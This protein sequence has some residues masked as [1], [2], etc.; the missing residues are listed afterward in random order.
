MKKLTGSILLV[1][2]PNELADLRYCSGFTAVD[3]V[4]F[5]WTP[6]QRWLVVP[7]MEVGRAKREVKRGVK[8][9]SPETLELSSTER[10]R[11]SSWALAL[12]RR[13]HTRQIIVGSIFP[14]GVARRLERAGIRVS[15]S[16]TVLFPQRAVKSP[17]ELKKMRETQAAA[18]AAMGAAIAVIRKSRT[19]RHG[20]LVKNGRSLTAEAVERVIDEVLLERNC[21]ALE[22][23][24]ACGR[25]S[26]APHA[27]GRGPL[28]INKPIVIDIFPR[29]KKHGYWGDMTRTV[30][31]GHASSKV[32]RMYHAVERAQAAALS[33]VKPGVGVK[34]IHRE[35][36]RVFK[37]AG[38]ATTASEG[39]IHGTG[40]GVGLDIHEGPNVGLNKERLRAGNV[41]TIEPGLYYRSDGGVRIEDTVVVTPRGWKYLARSPH[42]FEV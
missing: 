40:H 26:A 25:T 29:H 6:A 31:K 14:I 22:S 20:Q 17:D 18:A 16:N 1:G 21:M 36:Q 4:V 33:M 15:V 8:V 37:Q 3:P 30:V 38:F 32:R 11:L 39:F 9:V 7:G 19:D 27:R 28:R 5:L 42:R 13:M 35:V 34:S 41:V 12:L 23:I 2:S 10:R 24:V